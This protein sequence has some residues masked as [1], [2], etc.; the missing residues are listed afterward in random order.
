MGFIRSIESGA[1]LN[2]DLDNINR[3]ADLN[4]KM[5]GL[6]VERGH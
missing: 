6:V 4:F 1:A 2:G 3:F 5:L